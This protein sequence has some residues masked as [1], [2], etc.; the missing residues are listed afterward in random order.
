MFSKLHFERFD[1]SEG[2]LLPKLTFE[3]QISKL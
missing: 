1:L 3:P 2:E